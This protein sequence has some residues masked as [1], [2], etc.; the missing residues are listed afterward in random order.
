MD[1][2]LREALEMEDPDLHKRQICIFLGKMKM[3]LNEST[4]VQD[5]RH[6]LVTFMAKAISVRYLIDKVSKMCPGEP[7]PSEQWVRLQFF[8][9]NSC[10]KTASQYKSQFPVKFRRGNSDESI[11]I[12]TTVLHYFVTCENMQSPTQ[13]WPHLFALMTN[14]G[15]NVLHYFVTCENMQSPTE[16]WPHLFALI[17]NI[18]LNVGNLDI[19]LLLL[20]EAAVLW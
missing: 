9:K 7:I 2:R 19:Q 11:W 13:L 14:I 17:T 15:L 10:A 18:G 5:R 6:G 4:A 20:N 1:E 12:L 16:L 3:Y 8:P